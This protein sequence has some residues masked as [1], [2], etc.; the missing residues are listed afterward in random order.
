[1]FSDPTFQNFQF[2]QILDVSILRIFDSVVFFHCRTTSMHHA[3]PPPSPPPPSPSPSPALPPILSF[4][5]SLLRDAINHRP[6]KLPPED[7][8]RTV[9]SRH[10]AEGLRQLAHAVKR[11]NKCRFAETAEG[12]Q[13]PANGPWTRNEL[14]THATG[15]GRWH[16]CRLGGK[17]RRRHK[18]YRHYMRYRHLQA[19]Q[20]LQLLQAS[21]RRLR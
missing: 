5:H 20:P 16:S 8:H 1:M 4:G 6:L 9:D 2:L 12:G 17:P 21:L 18:R 14:E 11:R 15:E 10:P 13:M 3:H 7:I 19:L